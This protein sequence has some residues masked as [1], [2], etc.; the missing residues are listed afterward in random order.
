MWSARRNASVGSWVM[1]S[2]GPGKASSR[3][4]GGIAGRHGDPEHVAGEDPWLPLHL[5][6]R[7]HLVHVGPVGRGE[8][9]G[10]DALENLF[11]QSGTTAE[12]QD[13][14]ESPVVEFELGGH[15]SEHIGERRRRRNEH[16]A[17][18][19]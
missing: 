5:P 2:Q 3:H 13:D 9:V 10:G 1:R 19:F 16:D 14:V 4:S 11:T 6:G 12:V 15:F 7:N 17:L 18:E 8:H